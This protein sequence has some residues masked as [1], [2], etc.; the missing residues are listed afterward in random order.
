M[1]KFNTLQ[2]IYDEPLKP[3]GNSNMSSGSWDSEGKCSELGGS[4]HQICV[5]NIS[6]KE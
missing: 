6:K 2:N 3:C 4:V 5:E 1:E